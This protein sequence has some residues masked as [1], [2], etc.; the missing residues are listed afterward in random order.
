MYSSVLAVSHVNG[1]TPDTTTGGD[2]R[3]STNASQA[4]NQHPPPPPSGPPPAASQP[5]VP[6]RVAVRPDATM[7][8]Q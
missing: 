5:A 6:P 1:T 7:D 2:H 8:T 4:P 3:I